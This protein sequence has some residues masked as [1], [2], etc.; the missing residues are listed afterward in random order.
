MKRLTFAV[1]MVAVL[2]V[3][4]VVGLTIQAPALTGAAMCMWTP[5]MLFAGYAF[6]KAGGAVRNPVSMPRKAAEIEFETP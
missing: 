6:A 2:I 5:A 4:F 1:A 3:A